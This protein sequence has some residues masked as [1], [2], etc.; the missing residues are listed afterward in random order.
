MIRIILLF[1]FIFITATLLQ[2]EITIAAEVKVFILHSY[3]QEY[4]WTKHENRGLVETLQQHNPESDISFSTEYLDTKRVRFTPSYED[5]FLDYL[6]T[7]YSEYQPDIIFLT[8]DNALQFITHNRSKIFPA[9]PVVFCGVNNISFFDSNPSSNSYG[10]FEVKDVTANLQLIKN[11]FPDVEKVTFIGDN[12]ATYQA[13][14][15]QI[16]AAAALNFPQYD[17]SFLA[18]SKFDQVENQLRTTPN[19]VLVL[20]TIG[21]FHDKND[22]VLSI[23]TTINRL[24]SHGNYAI[25]SMEDVYMQDGVLGGIVTSGFAQGQRAA[26]LG[27]RLL[28]HQRLDETERYVTGDNI[29]TFEHNELVRLE[30]PPSRLPQDSVIINKPLSIYEEFRSFI[31]SALVTFILLCVLITFLLISIIRRRKAE[32][33]LKT[34][35]NFLNSVLDNLPDMVFV[36]EAENLTFVSLNKVGESFFNTPANKVIGKNDYDFF[37]KEDADF[38][39]ST[40]REVLT[41]KN[42]LDIPQEEIQTSFGKRY[43]HTKKIPLFDE[44]NDPI[45]LLGISRDITNELSAAKEKI[46][47]ENKLTQSQKME[48]IGTL[49][50]GIA[51]DFNNILSSIIGFTELAQLQADITPGVAKLLDGTLKGADR[52]KHLI[53]QILTFSRKNEQ[54]RQPV[55][56]ADVVHESIT[57]L[58]STLPSNLEIQLEM[59]SREKIFADPTQMHQV[60]MNLC[61]NSYHAMRG[62]NGT[63]M[64][65][66]QEIQNGI[67]P[68]NDNFQD[69]SMDACLHL[70]V[71]DSGKGMSPEVLERIFDPYFTTKGPEAGTGLGLAVVH[72]IIK[73]HG[74]QIVVNSEEGSGTTFNIYLPIYD[75]T[76]EDSGTR[77]LQEYIHSDVNSGKKILLVDDEPNLLTLATSYLEDYGYKVQSFSDSQKALEHFYTHS[78]QYA[79]VIT[80]MTMPNLTG[81]ELAQ[82]IIARRP[83]TKIILCTGYSENINR[84]KALSLGISEYLEKPVSINKMLAALDQVLHQ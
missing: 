35:R 80:D 18:H 42:L 10:V 22:Q 20:T 57:L 13:I 52:A 7:K 15:R 75:D 11:L 61:T 44:K 23:P 40:D 60:V 78:E 50:G 24:K 30:I 14:Y 26:I 82:K 73:S 62:N 33:E 49:A 79:A 16:L 58:Q 12:S 46:E 1:Q 19:S 45:F 27:S 51:H 32:N 54:D 2:P 71:G 21:G 29:P 39:T 4:P 34:S 9:A 56:L 53:R 69:F 66:L 70:I 65:K 8:D 55:V 36:K 17:F 37:T 43:L 41:N 47:L 83:T 31:I 68:K 67:S 74:G 72:G 64:L 3:H 59:E 25:I 5:F 6:Q 48:S 81:A 38:F 84:Q 76:E 63:L 77:D 28:A